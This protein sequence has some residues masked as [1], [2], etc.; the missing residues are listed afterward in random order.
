MMKNKFTTNRDTFVFNTPLEVGL[1]AL[2]I[3][4]ELSPSLI[5]LNRLVIYDYLVTHSSDVD[6]NVESL[7]PSI[8]NRSGEIIIK[9]KVMQEGIDLMYSRELVE[10]VYTK[11]GVSYRANDLSAYFIDYF[12]S[13]YAREI[14]NY[15]HW[16]NE[17]FSH[18]SD[19]ELEEYID[20]N[21]H[22]WG[23]EFTKESLVRGGFDRDE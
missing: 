13:I 14:R 10:I 18:L 4:N 21:I 1:R 15:S 7:H 6:T 9:R 12:D 23:S 8:P 2:M 3:L 5:D 11:G 16:L 22:K 20:E 17:T 19:K